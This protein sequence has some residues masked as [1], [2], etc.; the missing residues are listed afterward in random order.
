MTRTNTVSV[1]KARNCSE[2]LR[3]NCTFYTEPT[4]VF[5]PEEDKQ[6]TE[7]EEVVFRV[8]V[9]GVP[10]PQ[11]TWYCDGKEIVSN[12]SMELTVEGSLTILSAKTEHSGVYRFVATNS[13]GKVEKDVRLNVKEKEESVCT[14]KKHCVSPISVDEFGDYVTKCHY[15]D[16]EYFHHQFTV[17][18]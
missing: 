12:F 3:Y 4:I 8:K 1:K 10:E 11:V 16:N 18:V 17:S 14:P 9:I 5:F 13:V 15:N 7:G 2:L 6:V